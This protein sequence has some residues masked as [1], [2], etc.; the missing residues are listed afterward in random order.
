MVSITGV[1]Q[2]LISKVTGHNKIAQHRPN[3]ETA[4]STRNEQKKGS[5]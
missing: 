5:I 4:L 3:I 2:A 1:F